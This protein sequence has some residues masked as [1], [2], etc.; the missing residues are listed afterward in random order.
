VLTAANGRSQSRCRLTTLN[1]SSETS[2]P[3]FASARQPVHEALAATRSGDPQP[4]MD[5]RADIDDVT[6]FGAW[7]PIERRH[8]R[9]VDTFRWVGDR[10]NGGDATEVEDV[11]TFSS[12]DLV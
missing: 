2:E 11:V 5:T 7:G 4:Y 10:F 1:A 3:Q 6:L 9:L 12:G 8:Q